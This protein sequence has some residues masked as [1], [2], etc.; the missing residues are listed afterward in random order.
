VDN[1]SAHETQ[2]VRYVPGRA[3]VGSSS[4]HAGLFVWLNQ[5]EFWFSK[6]ERDVTARG[7]FTRHRPASQAD[8]LYQALQHDRDA[9]SLVLRGPVAENRMTAD[10]T[11]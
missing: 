1:L 2:H 4:L 11:R 7:I 10:T 8:A 9:H 3:S 5:V 6:I